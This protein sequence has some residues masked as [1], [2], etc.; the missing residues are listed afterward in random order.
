MP[1][2]SMILPPGFPIKVA[3]TVSEPLCSG[4]ELKMPRDFV[5]FVNDD[6]KSYGATFN[7]SPKLLLGF[8]TG[9]AL[10]WKKVKFISANQSLVPRRRGIYA[11][12]VER[13]GSSLP[14]HGYVMYVGISGDRSGYDLRKRYGDYLRYKRNLTRP[15]VHYMLNNWGPC[16]FFHYAVVSDKRVSLSRLEKSVSDALVPPFSTSDFSAKIRRGKKALR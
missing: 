4:R 9:V 6:L 14:P 1:E 10:D 12:V 5:R 16:L 3:E 8:S 7:L 2:A 15:V 13:N 11:F